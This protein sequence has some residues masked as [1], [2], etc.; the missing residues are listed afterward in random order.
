HT[1]D[2]DIVGAHL[3]DT[4]KPLPARPIIVRLVTLFRH[5][6]DPPP[7]SDDRAIIGLVNTLGFQLRRRNKIRAHR[8]LLRI[9]GLLID[10][11][12]TLRRAYTH[13]AASCHAASCQAAASCHAAFLSRGFLSR[14]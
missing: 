9:P 11:L 5:G 6:S 13:R 3:N 2:L 14:G 8:P 12:Y 4:G 10:D 1:L 7:G